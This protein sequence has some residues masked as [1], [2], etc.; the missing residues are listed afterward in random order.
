MEKV[1]ERVKSV[2][3]GPK[4]ALTAIKAEEL[5]LK[6]FMK[7][8][9]AIVAAIPAIAQF[10]GRALVGDPVF[11]R[12]SFFGTLFFAIL[13]YVLSLVGVFVFGKIVNALADNF[14]ST[15]NDSN[16]F[17]LA[18]YAFTPGFVAGVFHIVPGLRVLSM[19][20]SL[21]GIY[22]LYIGLPILMDTPED[23]NTAYTIVSLI[24]GLI[25]M[26]V[27]GTIATDIALG[28]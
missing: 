23:K 9:V 28:S 3:L 22:I 21:Y 5:E 8:Y 20:G 11:G 19:L 24:I 27:I 6:G 25:V 16:A 7:D 2:L 10:I 4:D 1:I 13:Y 12:L 17:K 15:K 18:V 14:N 26:V